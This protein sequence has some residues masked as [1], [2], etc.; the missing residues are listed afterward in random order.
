MALIFFIIAG[1]VAAGLAAVYFSSYSVG[2]GSSG[3]NVKSMVQAQRNTTSYSNQKSGPKRSITD[4]VGE[5]HRV[6]KISDSRL[7][8]EKKLRYAQWN[9]S[10]VLFYVL[11]VLISLIFFLIIRTR[12][13]FMLQVIS[14]S[15]GPLFMASRLNIA[16]FKR[17]N[18]FDK[19]YPSFLLSLVGLL[20]TG[21]NVLQ[22][23]QSAAEG[24]DPNS[25]VKQEVDLMLERLR[26]GIPE[27]Q[28]IGA[29]G[30]DV[31]HEEIELFVQALLLSRRVGGNL[32]DTLDRLAK[33]V[34]KRQ[35]FR[36]AAYQ[37]VGMQRG[38]IWMILGVLIS[39][40]TY[41]YFMSPELVTG[42][43]HDEF[44]WQ[45]W[46]FGIVV[47][48]IGIFWIRQVTKMRV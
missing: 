17:F 36:S 21:M 24:L 39:I 31:S 48:L 6:K 44:G 9:I 38:S 18:A 47:I 19:D 32:S 10:P 2:S 1:L 41:I 33:Q 25:L 11:A 7:T 43:W 23:L 27:E 3:D 5:E 35:Y 30:E 28:S 45:V 42:A 40:L 13:N 8:L 12:F 15:A 22:G 14:L 46:Q 29:F 26:M 37:A 16:V 20:K 4:T 34:R